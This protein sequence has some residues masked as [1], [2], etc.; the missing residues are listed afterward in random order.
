LRA[1][2]ELTASQLVERLG[3]PQPT[4]STHLACLRWCGFV[5]T[6]REHRSIYNR[7]GDER[8]GEMLSLAEALLEENVE[9]VAACCTIEAKT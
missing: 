3:L 1:E 9:H 8:V 5:A 2:G 7:I 4:V 6:R